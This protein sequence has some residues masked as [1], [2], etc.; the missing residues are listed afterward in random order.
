[1]DEPGYGL[2]VESPY[3][4]GVFP[5]FVRK[6]VSRQVTVKV[7]PCGGVNRLMCKFPGYLSALEVGA[8][9]RPVDKAIVI[10]DCGNRDSHSLEHE[11]AVKIQSRQYAFSHSVQFFAVRQAMETWLLADDSAIS[12]V[13]R[14]R[15]GREVRPVQEQLEEIQDPKG[16]LRRLLSQAR[17]PYDA[18]VCGRSPHESTSNG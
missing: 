2:I 3:D 17:L 14:E 13:A 1:V 9:G 16:T 15:D 8:H 7:I 11:M 10:R 12:S 5:E 4:E 6:T 18:E